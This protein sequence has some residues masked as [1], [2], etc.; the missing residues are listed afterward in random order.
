MNER[1]NIGEKREV[2]SSPKHFRLRY[3]RDIKGNMRVSL[4]ELYVHNDKSSP[5]NFKFLF[6]LKYIFLP[7]PFFCYLEYPY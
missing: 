6:I 1:K 2:K 4:I 7:F 5:L 3:F